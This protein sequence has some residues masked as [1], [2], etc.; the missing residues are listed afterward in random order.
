[1][2]SLVEL[3]HELPK[4]IAHRGARRQAPENT[5]AAFLLA[6][7]LG[8]DGVELDTFRCATGEMVVTHDDDLKVWSNGEGKVTK[9]P[10]KAL[11]ELDF[12]SHFSSEFAKEQIPTLQE[13]IDSLD[14]NSFI[15]IEVK[16]LALR[17][18]QEVL[19][20]AKIIKLNN[21][22][23]RTIVSSF[24]PIVLRMLYKTDVKIPLGFLYQFKLPIYSIEY[25]FR[26]SKAKL[27]AL[28]PESRLIGNTLMKQ[29]ISRGYQINTWTVNETVEMQHLISLGVDSIIT[30]Y[31]DKLHKILTKH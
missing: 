9:T 20:V 4:N 3:L 31:P 8:A 26:S 11:K 14:K 6:E 24:N 1:M 19:E 23:H 27:Q 22:Y 12:G 30:D 15:N 2:K 13:V 5:L 17:P 29:A 21:I 25:I 7:K 18:I 16:T 28:H 10:L